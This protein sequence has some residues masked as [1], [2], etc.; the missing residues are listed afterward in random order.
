MRGGVVVTSVRVLSLPGYGYELEDFNSVSK[1]QS[2]QILEHGAAEAR[3]LLFFP[4][5]AEPVWMC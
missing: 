5:T 4:C 2:M 3:R 1:V